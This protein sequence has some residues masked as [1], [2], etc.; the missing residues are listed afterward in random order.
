MSADFSDYVN[1]LDHFFEEVVL[2]DCRGPYYILAHSTGSL[3]ALLATPSLVN[4]VRRMVLV[5]PFLTYTGFPLSMTG[6]RP[7][8]RR[9]STG[10]ASA[11]CMA[12]GGRGRA[13]RRRSR[14]TC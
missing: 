2:P 14:P 10:S 4:R 12:P 3:V 9:C 7:H 8:R 5:A 13:A 11:A 1:D 6:D